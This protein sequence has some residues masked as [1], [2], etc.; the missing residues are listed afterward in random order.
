MDIKWTMAK[1]LEEAEQ[2]DPESE[3][4]ETKVKPKLVE[5]HEGDFSQEILA[6]QEILKGNLGVKQTLE[7]KC[8]PD[9]GD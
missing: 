3:L 4:E 8:I 6:D 9:C 2:A 1:P 5:E 7:G